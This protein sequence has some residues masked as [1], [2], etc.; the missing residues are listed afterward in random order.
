MNDFALPI[1]TDV[2]PAM[3]P[4]ILAPLVETLDVADTWGPPA[5]AVAREALTAA[6]RLYG[7]IEDAEKALLGAAPPGGRRLLN[8]REDEFVEAATLAFSR[9]GPVIDR[10][11]AELKTYATYFE[12]KLAKV[13]D[14][15]DGRGGPG[16][17]MAT[18]IRTHLKSL[19]PSE[20]ILFLGRAVD[21]GDQQTVAAFLS[22][23]AFLSGSD[24]KDQDRV[25]HH[26]Y[27]KWDPVSSAQLAAV[28]SMIDH[29]HDA[30][31]RLMERYSQALNL[32][33]T[34]NAKAS[35]K[36]NELAKL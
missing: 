9:N 3:H 20:R 24:G 23:P 7:A 15:P 26:A 17:A 31:G 1:R 28:R 11:L 4:E 25:R 34:P 33:N 12:A 19:K 30:G 5:L 32:R 16:V 29:V 22:A 13:V 14:Y 8:G 27:E 2:P 21:G 35:V 10:R 6:Y 18:E 36:L